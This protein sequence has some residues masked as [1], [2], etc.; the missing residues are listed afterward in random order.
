MNALQAMPKP[1]PKTSLKG[2]VKKA[3]RIHWDRLTKAVDAK[4]RST[5]VQQGSRKER[6]WSGLTKT[7]AEVLLDWL[8]ANGYPPAVLTYEKSTGFVVHLP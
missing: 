2:L 3:G 7:R 4:G 8:E 5:P 6:R 1:G